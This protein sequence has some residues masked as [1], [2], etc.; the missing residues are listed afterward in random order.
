MASGPWRARRSRQGS[1]TSRPEWPYAA[2]LRLEGR[3]DR[4]RAARLERR[5]LLDVE[6]LHHAVLD[7][8]G[9]ALRSDAEAISGAVAITTSLITGTRTITTRSS[10]RVAPA[11]GVAASRDLV[12][13]MA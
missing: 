4:L 13:Q 10:N 7:D 2:P 12:F 1:T 9:A 6:L 5:R 3:A 8:C 11:A